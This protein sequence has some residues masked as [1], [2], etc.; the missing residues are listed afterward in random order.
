MNEYLFCHTASICPIFKSAEKNVAEDPDVAKSPLPYD[1]IVRP[2][3][4]KKYECM[5][6]SLAGNNVLEDQISRSPIYETNCA[7]IKILNKANDS[8]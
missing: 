2:D 8:V 4:T 3:D 1:I 7:L 5:A 6:M